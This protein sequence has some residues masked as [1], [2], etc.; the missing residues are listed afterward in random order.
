MSKGMQ[1]KKGK[2]GK[3]FGQ[4]LVEFTVL[5]PILLMMLSGLIEFG[6]LLNHYL[7]LVDAAREA[8]RFAADDDPLIRGGPFDGDTD[9]T[10][11][12]LAQDMTLDSINIG[13][14]GQITLDTITN[15][16]IVISTFSV[17]NGLV[18][19]R[20]PDGAP[21]GL[22]YAGNQS[23][24]FTDAMVNSMLNPV[25]PNAG[26]V[27]VEIFYEYHMVLGLP[28]IQMFVSDPIMLHAYSMM[29]NSAVE[30]TPTP[31]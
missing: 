23:S 11:Y 13:S 24:K 3:S 22:S 12:Q 15:D 9:D 1:K 25:A 30:P 14:G 17:M 28:W 20:F 26:I 5:L 7:D 31:P 27:L 18:D 29:P 21:M 6:F 16:D 2:R 10:F 8:A 4:S 19:R